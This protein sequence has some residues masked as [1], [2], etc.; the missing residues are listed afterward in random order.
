MLHVA[1]AIIERDGCFLAVQ[2]SASMAMPGLWEFPGGKLEPGETA[3]TC[4]IREIREEL[5]I[6]LILTE[7][8]ALCDWQYPDFTIR[9]YPYI[10]F[11][12][13]GELVLHEHQAFCWLKGP[14]P[15]LL[16]WAPADLPVLA[17]YRAKRWPG[18]A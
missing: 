9:L 14:D 10:G 12:T 3:E 11:W 13:Q 16:E 15:E 8:L 18:I 6:D 1:C 2:R 17:Q 4:L 7:A 5:G